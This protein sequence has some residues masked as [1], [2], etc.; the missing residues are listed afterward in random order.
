MTAW[1]ARLG[2]LLMWAGAGGVGVAFVL[3]VSALIAGA[4]TWDPLGWSLGGALAVVVGAGMVHAA[5]E[6]R[7]R[8]AR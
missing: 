1:L 7:R 5:A 4:E 3:A 2:F 6:L 8:G